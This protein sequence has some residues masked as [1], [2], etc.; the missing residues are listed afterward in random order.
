MLLVFIHD[1]DHSYRC[2]EKVTF[3][4]QVFFLDIVKGTK[5]KTN[6]GT[7]NIIGYVL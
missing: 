1:V 2:K 3:S 6:H 7:T 5:T 4:F